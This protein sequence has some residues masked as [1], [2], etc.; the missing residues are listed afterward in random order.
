V[1]LPNMQIQLIRGK[2]VACSKVP[3]KTCVATFSS[4]SMSTEATFQ[5]VSGQSNELNR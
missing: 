3:N 1:L 5:N 2:T 4:D